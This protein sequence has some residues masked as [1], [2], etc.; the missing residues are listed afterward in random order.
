MRDWKLVMM[1]AIAFVVAGIA[2][3]AA[4]PTSPM[5]KAKE[6]GEKYKE[7]WKKYQIERQKYVQAHQKYRDLR[8]QITF[9]HAKKFLV[10]GCSFAE[11]WL[12]RFRLYIENSRIED[13]KKLELLSEVD[14][15]I[16]TIKEKKAEINESE[17]P[18]ELREAAKE[19]REAW[20][21]IRHN[22]GVMV[23]QVAALKLELIIEKAERVEVRLEEKVQQLEAYGINT[24]EL[25]AI[26]EEYSE[27]LENAEESVEIALEL[28]EEGRYIEANNELKKAT[29]EI[30]EAFKDIKIFVKIIR[31]KV[32]QGRIFFGNE[33]GEVWAHGDGIARLEGDAVVNVRG[34]GTLTVSPISAVITV[35]G[36]GNVTKDEVNDRVIYEGTGKA[37]VRGEG[38]LVSIVGEN[39][40]LF[41]KGKGTLYLSGTGF[42]KVKKLPEEEMEFH[43]YNNSVTVQIGSV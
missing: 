22:L 28:Y 40:S 24:S 23:G 26:L 38:I 6:I 43:E 3:T 1:L 41:A 5:N 19:L 21:E 18:E 16:D 42:Y 25:E 8:N 20:V 13:E 29:I 39:I 9:N 10:N 31:E 30:K 37:I 12:E 27:H 7:A 32:S 33:T 34:S 14:E 4:E 11:R 2:V 17:S 36:F 15:Y 35:V